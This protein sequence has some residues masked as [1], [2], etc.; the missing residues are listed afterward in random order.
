M[1]YVRVTEERQ[2]DIEIGTQRKRHKSI[3]NS[4][5]I[6]FDLV[7]SFSF[8]Y[9]FV[10]FITSFCFCYINVFEGVDSIIC[11][12]RRA[13]CYRRVKVLLIVLRLLLFLERCGCV[14]DKISIIV[15]WNLH[16]L[17]CSVSVLSKPV[18]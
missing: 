6:K 17:I 11:G 16:P 8:S 1:W 7:F 12:G 15:L 14:I 13:I 10:R 9:V 5:C 3:Q 18:R 4:F 2:T